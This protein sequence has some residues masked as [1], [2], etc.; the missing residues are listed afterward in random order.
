MT[1]NWSGS[2]L[3]LGERPTIARKMTRFFGLRHGKSPEKE[4]DWEELISDWDNIWANDQISTDQ[5]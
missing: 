3:A 5:R 2:G 1:P 4:E